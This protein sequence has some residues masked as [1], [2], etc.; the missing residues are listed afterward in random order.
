MCRFHVTKA[1]S[2]CSIKRNICYGLEIEDGWPADEVPTTEDVEE[3]ARLANAHDFIM[4]LP[5]GYDTVNSTAM[6]LY[7]NIM[8]MRS[9]QWQRGIHHLITWAASEPRLC[10]NLVHAVAF[11]L[12]SKLLAGMHHIK[13]HCVGQVVLQFIANAGCAGLWGQGCSLVRRTEAAHS[14]SEGTCAQAP[15]SVAG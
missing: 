15:H 9:G 7:S 6:K 10:C 11:A 12:C 5:Q 2:A 4:G 3:A 1:A 8:T 14:Y 13:H